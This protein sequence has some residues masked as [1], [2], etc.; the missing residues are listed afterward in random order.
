MNPFLGDTK[1]A[2]AGLAQ[3]WASLPRGKK[4]EM[5]EEGFG[6]QKKGFNRGQL[7]MGSTCVRCVRIQSVEIVTTELCHVIL[8]AHVLPRKMLLGE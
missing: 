5:G 6:L 7:D 3:Q 8:C 2:R 4:E 1:P